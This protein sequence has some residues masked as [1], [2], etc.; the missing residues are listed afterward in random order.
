MFINELLQKNMFAI[1]TI[2][3]KPNKELTA[4]LTKNKSLRDTNVADNEKAPKIATV[5]NKAFVSAEAW[6][7]AA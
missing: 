4:A 2:D 7:N 6:N 3:S 1:D 5:P